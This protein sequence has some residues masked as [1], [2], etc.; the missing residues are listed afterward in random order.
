MLSALYIENL[1]VIEKTYIEFPTGFSVFTGE[2]GAGKSIVID[3]INACLGQRTSRDIVRTGTSKAGVTAVF[4]DL[5]EAVLRLLLQNGY[6]LEGGEL[7]IERSIHADGRS[8][9][10]LNG[11]PAPISLLREIGGS[12]VN[13][14]G[15]HDNQTLLSPER[16]L[17][18]LDSFGDL[19]GELTA[20]QQKFSELRKVARRIQLLT[21]QETGKEKRAEM[22]RYQI[23][24]IQSARLTQGIEER[25]TEKPASPS[26]GMRMSSSA[27]STWPGMPAAS[28][29]PS[30]IFRNSQRQGKPSKGWPSTSPPSLPPC[31]SSCP[32]SNT[33]SRRRTWL[34]RG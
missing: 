1:A 31:R 16:H 24:E 19:Q 17:E 6:E 18:L 7:V 34:S 28:W 2:T 23:E 15:Q 12:L 25:L 33:T 21:K 9:A 27:P 30:P 4:R 22:L 10:R 14:H 29:L 8:V 5:P 11:R 13:I 20:Y 3:A 26:A 32:P